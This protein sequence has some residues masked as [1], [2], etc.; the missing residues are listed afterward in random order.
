MNAYVNECSDKFEHVKDVVR[1]INQFVK[2]GEVEKKKFGEVMTPISLVKEMLD[3]LPKEVWSNPNLKWLDPANGAGTFP[4]VVI[5][6][7]MNGLKDWEPDVEKR[8]KHIVEKM[9]YVCE[10]QSRNVFLW[11]CGVDPKDEYTTNTYWGSFLDE[12]FDKHM[13]EVWGV[14]KFDIV[15]GNPPYN[16]GTSGGNGGRDLWDKF[17][18]KSETIISKL[19]YLLYVHPPKW[20]RPENELY[21]IFLRNN[22]IYLE[23]HSK[24]DGY[25][26]FNAVT[27]YDWY[28]LQISDYSG[29][30]I[31]ID[32]KGI[33]NIAKVENGKLVSN[34]DG[35]M[36]EIS[37]DVTFPNK[38]KIGK[39]GTVTRA[40]G[41][42]FKLGSG[43]W[44]IVSSTESAK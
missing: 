34:T 37:T 10:L 32:E 16:T 39:D 25:K 27:R 31:I 44:L 29:K 17:L 42:K 2:D 8:Y 1:I 20:R 12:G 5:Y 36:S 4:F 35:K 9:I 40:D 13:K 14:E 38:T 26:V 24:K 6:K 18:I 11:L 30:S 7:L 19:G 22:L 23:I 43:E 28:L 41:T 3:T 33:K 21:N 15:V